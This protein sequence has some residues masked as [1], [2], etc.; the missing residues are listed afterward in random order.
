MLGKDRAFSREL[1]AKRARLAPYQIGHAGQLQEWLH[2]WDL[3][4]PDIHHRHLSPLYGL[5]PSDQITPAEPGLFAAAR[6]LLEIR[7]DHGGMGWAQTWRAACWARLLDG[8]RAYS[9]VRSLPGSWTE[10]NL[11]DKPVAQLDG[12]FGGDRGNAAAKPRA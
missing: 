10:S 8:E 11:F 5:F 4:A 12:N 2:D 7:G 9:L 6:K 1:L 3:Q